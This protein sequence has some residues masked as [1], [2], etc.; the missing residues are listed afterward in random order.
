MALNYFTLGKRIYFS[1]ENKFLK[2]LQREQNCIS[3]TFNKIT[4]KIIQNKKIIKRRN[5]F[6]EVNTLL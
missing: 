2:N 6:H 3:S 4:I 1:N 5:H